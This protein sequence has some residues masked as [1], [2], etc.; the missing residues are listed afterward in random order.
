MQELFLSIRPRRLPWISIGLI[1]VGMP[2]GIW[3]F[4]AMSE[5]WP[6]FLLASI[7]MSAFGAG[8]HFSVGTFVIGKCK[9]DL[10]LFARL[11][12]PLYLFNAFIGIAFLIAWVN[13]AVG[14]IEVSEDALESYLGIIVPIIAIISLLSFLTFRTVAK[15][16]VAIETDDTELHSDFDFKATKKQLGSPFGMAK[17]QERVQAIRDKDPMRQLYSSGP[18]SYDS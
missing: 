14:N 15:G 6:V 8:W 9:S 7:G 18:S 3:S 4:S 11:Y 5:R 16:L 17:I 1:G 12:A 2:F 13:L 10:G